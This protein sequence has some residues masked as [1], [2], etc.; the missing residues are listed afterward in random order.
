MSNLLGLLEVDGNPVFLDGLHR[1]DLF[2]QRRAGLRGN[3][4]NLAL[5]L[6]LLGDLLGGSLFVRLLIL[7]TVLISI[8]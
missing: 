2:R 6:Y 7:S 3:D 1:E 8:V 4:L 5:G